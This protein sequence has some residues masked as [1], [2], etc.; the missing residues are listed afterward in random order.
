MVAMSTLRG[1]QEKSWLN[2][3]VSDQN[4]YAMG[5][6]ENNNICPPW[7]TLHT[8]MGVLQPGNEHMSMCAMGRGRGR[9]EGRRGERRGERRREGER[10]GEEERGGERSHEYYIIF[11]FLF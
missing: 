4:P 9:E 7:L 1:N 5:P 10:G 6:A 11:P 3:A 2:M 8:S